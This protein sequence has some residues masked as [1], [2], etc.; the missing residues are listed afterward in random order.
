[1]NVN[2]ELKLSENLKSRGGRV[3]G[4]V[5]VNNELY[6]CKTE[7]VGVIGEMGVGP[8]IGSADVIQEFNL[9]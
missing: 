1:M 6:Y 3:G 8:G 2:Q 4:L 9:L 5:G 7:K